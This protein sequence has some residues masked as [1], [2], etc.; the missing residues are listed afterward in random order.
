MKITIHVLLFML[1]ASGA[2]SE[3]LRS[4]TKSTDTEKMSNMGLD[5]HVSDAHGRYLMSSDSRYVIKGEFEIIDRFNG[6]RVNSMSELR[7]SKQIVDLK[8]IGIDPLELAAATMGD[9]D[10][11]RGSIVFF[12]PLSSSMKPILK[13]IERLQSTG[14]F[15]H[16]VPFPTK[17][18]TMEEINDVICGF[19]R[20]PE[21][22]LQSLIAG[23]KDF[24][25]CAVQEK[26]MRS[27]L[28]AALL[29]QGEMPMAITSS[30]RLLLGKSATQFDEVV[31]KESP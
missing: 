9:A 7:S 3:N 8:L 29:A 10:A 12:N 24:D 17:G 2:H 23:R 26:L 19:Q 27:L 31:A 6:R 20:D 13:K 15:V 28:T 14:Q 16:L 4:Y 22:T 18:N 1:L 11:T 5:M 21:A 25:H 30:G